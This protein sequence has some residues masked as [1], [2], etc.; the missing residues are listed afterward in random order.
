MKMSEQVVLPLTKAEAVILSD[1]LYRNGRKDEYFAD[2]AEQTVF[3][4]IEC[5]LEK[6]L[7]VQDTSPEA[8]G[9]AKDSLM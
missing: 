5:L 2:L 9:A 6:V 7:D 1:W 4:S 8:V 3:W